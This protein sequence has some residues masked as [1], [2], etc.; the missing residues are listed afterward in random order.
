MK[1]S[2]DPS[3]R[4]G[5][6]A[7]GLKIEGTT[8]GGESRPW[9]EAP[10]LATAP[11]SGPWLAED[12]SR[13]GV[14][15]IRDRDPRALAR[16][17]VAPG[18]LSAIELTS[19]SAGETANFSTRDDRPSYL[20]NPG[21]TRPAW[22]RRL[23]ELTARHREAKAR[24]LDAQAKARER[25]ARSENRAP[26]EI[27]DAGKWFRDRAKGQRERPQR[28]ANCQQTD[29]LTVTC[30]ACGTITERMVRCGVGM[31]CIS[32]RSAIV[33]RKRGPFRRA[34]A[35]VLKEAARAGLLRSNRRGGR[36]GEKLMTLTAPHLEGH[37]IEDRI[38]L[39]RAAWPLFLK[40]FNQFLRDRGAHHDAR[41][42][43]N[44][45][46]T[47]A[48]DGR[49]HPHCHVWIFSPFIPRDL[50]IE[51]WRASLIRA[52]YAEA[53][54]RH[55]M[56][57]IR[58]MT[59]GEKGANE[60]IKY[61]TKDLVADGSRIDPALYA[62]VYC[63]LDGVRTTQ[64]SRGFIKLAERKSACACG[65]CGWPPHVAQDVTL[66]ELTCVNS[67]PPFD[68]HSD[69]STTSGPGVRGRRSREI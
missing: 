62:R 15:E 21:I 22:V 59:N 11:A 36:W 66:L 57:D 27:R 48:I 69:Q 23:G 67:G 18:D 38:A 10:Q 49:G 29:R 61:M 64:G 56:I 2:R 34:R 65:A 20:D 42:F 54:L 8:P 45:E 24:S 6:S 28:V 12:V 40:M 25:K 33:Y 30:N 44:F 31:M 60:V 43:R 13:P 51:W 26:R 16:G 47:P 32:C 37:N 14:V 39:V 58:A 1:P 17:A 41:W 55:L 53:D 7:L 9:A 3:A 52:G 68:V 50:I 35:I 19:Q 5:A 4:C 46:W 63:A